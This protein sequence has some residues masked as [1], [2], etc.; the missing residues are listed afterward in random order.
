MGAAEDDNRITGALAGRAGL[1][2]KPNACGIDHA[3]T[4]LLIEKAFCQVLGG[5]GFA[6][7][8]G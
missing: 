4:M 8:R 7:R 3:D 5:I 6:L 2:T 1:E